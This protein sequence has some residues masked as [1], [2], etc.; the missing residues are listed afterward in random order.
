[1]RWNED[2]SRQVDHR[3]RLVRPGRVARSFARVQKP[4]ERRILDR[5]R[6]V[7]RNSRV[8]LDSKIVVVSGR[9]DLALLDVPEVGRCPRRCAVRGFAARNRNSTKTIAAKSPVC[10]EVSVSGFQRSRKRILHR[11][12]HKLG[13]TIERRRRSLVPKKSERP[14]NRSPSDSTGT[15]FSGNPR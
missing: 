14:G 10:S 6:E 13:N 8:P 15:R 2:R 4:P 9:A 1:M 3:A 5:V 12:A 7:E 11:R